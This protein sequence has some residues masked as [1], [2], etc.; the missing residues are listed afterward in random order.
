MK[1]SHNFTE[2]DLI[3]GLISRDEKVISRLYALYYQ[4]VRFFV[5]KN[6]GSDDD[7]KDI[8]QNAI[9]ILFQK[10]RDDGFR[11]TC[12]IKTYIH[13]VSRILWL[14]ELKKRQ[15]QVDQFILEEEC[16]DHGSDVAEIYDHNE[17]L[18]LYRSIFEKMSQNC[19]KIL[20][21][22][23]EGRSIREITRIMGFKNEQ[24]T[25]NRCYRCRLTLMKKIQA[26]YGYQELR[27]E[28]IEDG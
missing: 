12:S 15:K 25:K 11:L 10:F 18:F 26:T 23:H 8:F 3:N 21:L 19:Q 6:N 4:S 7:A 9:M 27:N 1:H 5:I 22:F 13:S 20:T 28:K 24:H 14:R 16:I 2:S 17:R